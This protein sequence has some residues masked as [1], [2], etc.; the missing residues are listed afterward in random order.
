MIDFIEWEGLYYYAN[1]P[2][3]GVFDWNLKYQLLPRF[4]TERHEE[5]IPFHT[6]IMNGGVYAIHRKY[7][8]ELGPYDEAFIVYGAENIE[9][10]LK[11]WLCGGETFEVPCSRVGHVF[12]KFNKFRAHGNITDYEGFNRKRLIEVWFEDYKKFVEL[13]EP[14]RYKFLEVGDLTKA[15]AYKKTHDCKPFEYFLKEIAPDLEEIFPTIETVFTSGTVRLFNTTEC[16]DTYNEPIGAQVHLYECDK[17]SVN[18]RPTQF[19]EMAYH[20]DIRHKPSQDCLDAFE[21]H[22]TECHLLFGN[23]YF[24]YDQVGSR[25][26]VL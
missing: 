20:R 19:F 22:T 18:P 10:S 2:S 21:F 17:N 4:P 23:Q 12:R 5:L 3:R 25:F 13:R 9:M 1:K 8:F 7:F 11:T 16:W 15:L 6:P 14:E 26:S 24:R